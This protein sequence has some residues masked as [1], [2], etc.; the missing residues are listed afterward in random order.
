MNLLTA[1]V[2]SAA[3]VAVGLGM[4]AWAYRRKP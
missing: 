3:L 4:L 2:L 1:C